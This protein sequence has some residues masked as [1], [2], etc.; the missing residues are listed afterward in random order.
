MSATLQIIIKYLNLFMLLIMLACSETDKKDA[1]CLV[2]SPTPIFNTSVSVLQ[3][4]QS[5]K[6]ITVIPAAKNTTGGLFVTT[7][8]DD[9]YQRTLIKYIYN[10][11]QNNL[12]AD[13]KFTPISVPGFLNLYFGFFAVSAKYALSLEFRNA[14]FLGYYLTPYQLNPLMTGQQIAFL[15]RPAS[16]IVPTIVSAAPDSAV[17]MIADNK[18]ID[19]L[20]F[21]YGVGYNP[22]ASLMLSSPLQ[23]L[24][25]NFVLLNSHIWVD[26]I[27]VDQN[28]QL[29][30][31]SLK[32]NNLTL[33]NTVTL[34]INQQL[35]KTKLLV[36]NKIVGLAVGDIDC[37]QFIDFVLAIETA[38]GD[39]NVTWLSHVGDSKFEIKNITLPNSIKNIRRLAV[40]DLNADNRDDLVLSTSK[41]IQV[42]L[43]ECQTTYKQ[44]KT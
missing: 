28:N 1:N 2:A 29:Q 38:T 40:G 34:L 23:Y 31:Y 30:V 11:T 6:A 12:I 27:G 13:N 18:Q 3:L 25:T 36:G 24:N 43:N 21:G 19:V 42:Y 5:I 35:D 10:T 4:A 16:R 17:V 20:N 26:A 7:N 33:E 41:D 14:A 32:N 39:N 8:N 15:D 37:D 9:T 22:V 44:E